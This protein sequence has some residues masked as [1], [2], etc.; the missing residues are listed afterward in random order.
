MPTN[1]NIVSS[2]LF[3]GLP[4]VQQQ[5]STQW[6]LL[7]RWYLL[8]SGR[9]H[10]GLLNHPILS[11][12]ALRT[13]NATPQCSMLTLYRPPDHHVSPP[14]PLPS[15]TSFQSTK[16]ACI[17]YFCPFPILNHALFSWASSAALFLRSCNASYLATPHGVMP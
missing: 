13:L 14:S 2:F 5:R 8:A 1:H 9:V 17:H 3:P 16:I 11:S 10:S 15:H 12:S 7:C 6:Q 4:Q